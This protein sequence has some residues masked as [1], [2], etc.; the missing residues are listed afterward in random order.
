[1]QDW[2]FFKRKKIG[3]VLSGGVA[4]GIAHIGVLKVI[5]SLGIKIDHI[6][7]TSMGA[8]IGSMYAAGLAPKDIEQ[9]ALKNNILDFIQF[10]ISYQAPF[11]S[12]PIEKFIRNAVGEVQFDQ[13]KIPLTVLSADIRSGQAVK[14][15]Q[16]SVPFAVR[17]SATFPG[18]YNPVEIDDKILVDGGVLNNF[19]ADVLAEEGVKLIIGS[20]V[21]SQNNKPDAD[22]LIQI[23]FRSLDLMVNKMSE[24]NR[25]LADIL[26]EP[27]IPPD[28]WHLD[29]HKARALVAAGEAAA[30]DNIEKL[31]KAVRPT[32]FGS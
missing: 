20:D 8:V 26:I 15:K 10:S 13:L 29:A 25:K 23:S 14:L 30:N 1:M 3:L 18:F 32:I 9:L 24:E 27:V 31:K 12:E 19:P 28:I 11:S 7:A 21:L 16:G 22:N 4:L 17:A 5:D 2:P 6:A